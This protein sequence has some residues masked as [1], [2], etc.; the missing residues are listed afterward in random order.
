MLRHTVYLRRRSQ[1]QLF[2]VWVT[3][4]PLYRSSFKLDAFRLCF[5]NCAHC[6]LPTLATLGNDFYVSMRLLGLIGLLLVLV[7]V[8]RGWVVVLVL[9]L[10]SSGGSGAGCVCGVFRDGGVCCVGCCGSGSD[11]GGGFGGG[12]CVACVVGW[13]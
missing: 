7:V 9:V 6:L 2:V 10:G 13:W 4:A 3:Y 8:D 1:N 11:G 5:S 12:N